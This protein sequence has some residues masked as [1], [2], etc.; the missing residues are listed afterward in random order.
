MSATVPTNTE[1][2][3]LKAI[4][5][6]A[7][8]NIA[9]LDRRAV[10]T[11]QRVAVLEAP[12]VIPPII[13]PVIPPVIPPIIPPVIPPTGLWP[14]EPVGM[15]L[16]TD[17]PL[18][19]LT[20]AGWQLVQRQTTNG[21]GVF[22]VPD[23]TAPISPP[24]VL[25]FRYA[26]GYTG[27]S[28]PGCAFY[29]PPPIQETYFAFSWKPSNPWQ[30]HPGSNVN[31]LAFLFPVSGNPIYIQM[32]NQGGQYFLTVEPEFAG[33]TR[34]LDPNR[35]ATPIV[36]GAWHLV[37]WYVKYGAPGLT[38]WWLDGVLQGE[39]ADLGTP[40][41]AGFSEYQLAPTWG[42]IGGT[43][44]ELDYQRYDHVRISRR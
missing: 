38:R 19:A 3:A 30:N 32:F 27:G 5:T 39:Y 13:P 18:N 2:L 41:D 26:V 43:K 34:R 15:T 31:K 42:G 14:N 28:E 22:S 8:A 16:V 33:D 24:N 4:V 23:P 29:N 36:L 7:V 11:D 6:Q 1:F 10:L 40:S 25:E 9:D 12:P 35:T 37:E 20:G 21:S 17:T 44:T